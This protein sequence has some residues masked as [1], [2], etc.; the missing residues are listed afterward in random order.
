[1]TA[2]V[3]LQ[4][5]VSYEQA[6]SM[7]LGELGRLRPLEV[8]TVPLEQAAGRV[9]AQDV[10]AQAPFP[11]AVRSAM[12]GFAVR[13][14]DVA[15]A[16][17][18]RPVALRLL[19]T[20]TAGVRELPALEP[21][22]C[23]RIMT[24]VPLPAG[25]D[26][27]V[28]QELTSLDGE[29]V[30]VQASVAAGAYTIPA[31][32]D[33]AAGEVVLR[34]GTWLGPGQLAMLAA[35][36]VARPAVRRAPRVAMAATGD[37]VVPVEVAEPAP[38]QVRNSNAYVVGAQVRQWGGTVR[39]WGIVPDDPQAM[40]RTAQAMA[41]EA[42]ALVFTGGMSVG[43]KDLV[44]PVL[45]QLGVR[46]VVHRVA[47]RP[48]RPFAFG[49]WEGRPVFGLPGTPG[50][51]MVAAEL[52]VRPLLAAWLGRSWEP[53]ECSAVLTRPLRMTPGRLRLARGYLRPGP[54]GELEVTPVSR[55]SSNSV[56][57]LADANAL[58][59]VPPEVER[60]EAG[61][62]VRVRLLQDL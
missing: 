20:V 59:F 52:F 14:A 45:E 62:R 2:E 41:Q 42:D 4:G 17:A 28:P 48:G 25:A 37:E 34:A 47:I 11:A 40:A 50:G 6:L 10:V 16:S 53:P 61:A 31:G 1:M 33:A 56:R 21:G 23:L 57:S 29:T 39:L 7:V 26:A 46:W 15:G 22:A 12:D 18:E 24:G 5:L 58:I 27:V 51:A 9:L 38:G 55:Q 13:S 19:G 30:R 60:L 54:S 32:E 44:R 43:A 8:E 49:V 36:G 35:L 3:G